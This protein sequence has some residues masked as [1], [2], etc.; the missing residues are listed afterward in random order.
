MIS[1]LFNSV[2]TQGLAT[3]NG[4]WSFIATEN[5]GGPLYPTATPMVVSLTGTPLTTVTAL[6]GSP[7]GTSPGTKV[8]QWHVHTPN[9]TGAAYACGLTLEVQTPGG[10][11]GPWTLSDEWFLTPQ[12]FAPAP[13]GDINVT[14]YGSG[15]TAPTATL[16]GGGG[17]GA[18]AT[19]GALANGAIIAATV[20]SGGTGYNANARPT[21][22]VSGGGGTGFA[23]FVNI[24]GGAIAS[25][26]VSNCGSGYTSAPTL[27]LSGGSGTGAV[28]TA[29]A[30]VN[31]VITSISVGNP[32]SNYTSSPAVTIADATGSGATAWALLLCRPQSTNVSDAA[33][34]DPSVVAML[35][36]PSGKTPTFCRFMD[37]TQTFDNE[38]NVTDADD[39]IQLTDFSWVSQR[40][41][42][43]T[44]TVAGNAVTGL[45][46]TF[47]G[48]NLSSAPAVVFTGGGGTGAAATVTV[49]GGSITGYT[50]TS[51]GSGYTSAPT[52]ALVGGN[53]TNLM[54]T[55]AITQIGPYT[56]NK[57]YVSDN[58]PGTTASA[59]YPA[60]DPLPYYWT[61][62]SPTF[63]DSWYQGGNSSNSWAAEA[64]TAL[65]HGL[66]TG[67]QIS[68]VGTVGGTITVQA[69]GGN[70]VNVTPT[71][72]STL[73]VYV[74]SPTTFAFWMN[75]NSLNKG[76]GIASVTS[77]AVSCRPGRH[78]HRPGPGRRGVR[79]PGRL[80]QL[81][82]GQQPP[83]QHP[84]QCDARVHPGHR[85]AACS[86]SS[87]RTC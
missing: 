3:V 55:F 35:T 40:L 39:L 72:A 38:S 20:T 80:L 15:Y 23:A 25:V 16:T 78:R 45:T 62:T 28:L 74:T 63:L 32:G 75:S 83:H 33:A 6:P 1:T 54:R 69:P 61:P 12:A 7:T 52:V 58:W 47:T 76:F 48:Q 22:T 65:P 5:A 4:V 49:A 14:A 21:V 51:G 79:G 18:T 53:T 19:V 27:G 46:F 68:W 66:K 41:P 36:T 67:Q 56:P 42:A 10:G 34:P 70:A 11:P 13:V 29:A 86:R 50:I 85:R 81:S 31:G 9:G 64:T 24:L 44:A 59:N 60:S 71:T 26:V 84:A 57:V 77:A 17:T 30:P 73:A 37:V 87:R 8:W 43:A 2:N 82:A